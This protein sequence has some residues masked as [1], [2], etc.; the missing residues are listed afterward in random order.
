MKVGSTPKWTY[1]SVLIGCCLMA[2][3]SMGLCVYS[4]GVFFEPIA[5]ALQVSLGQAS[6]IGTLVLVSMAC[7]TL[8]LPA[9]MKVLSYRVLMYSG[10]VLAA[11]DG[12]SRRLTEPGTFHPAEA[13]LLHCRFP[14][15]FPAT[16]RHR[17]DCVPP[18]YPDRT[19]CP[20]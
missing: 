18:I 19:P 16:V 15:P 12:F 2:G 8:L 4:A 5:T 10:L 9:L 6:L 7:C 13:G 11:G 1:L 17:T 20:K 14:Q 3:A